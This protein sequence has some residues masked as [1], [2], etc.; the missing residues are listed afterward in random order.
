MMM[1]LTAIVESVNVTKIRGRMTNKDYKTC[2]SGQIQ[3]RE[4]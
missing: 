1:F 2:W 4:N 3:S